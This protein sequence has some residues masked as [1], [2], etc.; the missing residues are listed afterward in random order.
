MDEIKNDTSNAGKVA[1]KL[2]HLSIVGRNVKWH[3]QSY[4][5]LGSFLKTKHAT[6]I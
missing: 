2:G 3:I 4:K 6:T 5:Q 1:E